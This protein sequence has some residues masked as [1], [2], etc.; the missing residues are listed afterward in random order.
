MHKCI[1]FFLGFVPFTCLRRVVAS[2][3]LGYAQFHFRV[4]KNYLLL[5]LSLS[6]KYAT[7]SNPA[8]ANIASK[9][10]AGAGA[11]V[12]VGEDV[13]V[14]G[15]GIELR[16]GAEGVDVGVRTEVVVGVEGCV[17][18]DGVDIGVGD[19]KGS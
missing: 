13:S 16:A 4:S 15:V 14:V 11:G 6:T 19:S 1:I 10:G 12:V 9:P 17:G 2:H 18:V 8:I 5:T 3:P 7:A